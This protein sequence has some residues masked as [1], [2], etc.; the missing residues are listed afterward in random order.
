[1]RAFTAPR[2]MKSTASLL[3]VAVAAV[4]CTSHHTAAG[5]SGVSA[6]PSATSGTAASNG[7]SA[8]PSSSRPAS[9][10][11]SLAPAPTLP[12]PGA[13]APTG[14]A[15][16]AS[17]AASA[18]AFLRSYFAAINAGLI[19]H[20][21]FAVQNYFL[22]TCQL[23]QSQWEALTQI[24]DQQEAIKGGALTVV[25]V[26]PVVVTQTGGT[27]VIALTGEDAGQIVASNG[28]G[29][30]TSSFKAVPPTHVAYTL[31]PKGS[32]WVIVGSAQV[33]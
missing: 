32:S 8:P 29:V 20:N 27:Q 6:L 17:V 9:A 15:P 12:T 2:L 21:F 11:A 4:G 13:P 22:P 18:T 26:G 3:L 25:N 19:S 30:V 28:A 23:C 16:P 24:A 33:K 1:M 31:A 5:L 14:S 7:V 10:T